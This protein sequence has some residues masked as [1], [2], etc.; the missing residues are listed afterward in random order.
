LAEAGDASAV[1]PVDGGAAPDAGGFGTLLFSS[2]IDLLFDID[3]SA[4][5]GDKQA[6][7]EAA[8]PDLLNRLINP[9]CVDTA[10]PPN[11]VGVSQNGQCPSGAH[12]EFAPVHDL[13]IG[14]VSS[15]LGSR[16][17]DSIC[18][19]N[20]QA[21][22]PFQNVSAH[23]D[24]QAHLLER[25]LV[26]N[27]TTATEGA[28]TDTSSGFL[29]WF[30]TG[31][32]NAGVPP[33]RGTPISNAT[34]LETDFSSLV[35]GVGVF[36]C[37]IESQMESWYR[38]LIQPD[39]YQ[40]LM[41]NGFQAQWS[42]IDTTILQQRHDF[43]R[44]D[45]LVAVIS[46]SDENDSEI[47]VRSLN[48]QGY[49]WMQRGFKPPH[50][51]SA[52]GT[53]PA[54]P[55]CVSCAQVPK[56]GGVSADPN[57]ASAYTLPNDWGWDPNLRHV[58]MKAKY[59]VDPQFPIQRYLNGLTSRTVPDRN[60]EYPSGA[61]AYQGQNDCTNP[62]FAAVLPDGTN[63]DPA[64]LCHLAVSERTPRLVFYA[65]IGGVPHELLHFVANDPQ[66]STL[67]GD[68]WVKILGQGLATFHPGMPIDSSTNN[69]YDTTGIDP[70]M[71]ESYQPRAGL[72]PP[73][74]ANGADPI[75]GREWITDQEQ[76][77]N[78]HV[79]RVDREFACIFPL[80]QPRD[81]SLPQNSDLC[82]CPATAGLT[83][84][85]TPPICD[86]NTQTQQV[87]AKAYPTIR[88]LLL[89]RLMA[90]QG[91]IGSICPQHVTEQSA[92]DPLYGY[93]PAMNMLIS[94]FAPA[95]R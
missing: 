20:A 13:H 51:S 72:Q 66:A 65:H 1:V 47:D 56:D 77:P 19:P 9:N 23:N 88:E 81:C 82:D 58:H 4:S 64:S 21:P 91:V 48:G 95:I 11:I 41:L 70:H 60:G 89:A 92:G 49:L 24:D 57:C 78:V 3:N 71:I 75:S 2:K 25:S 87:G 94:R 84:E 16:L 14:I 37:G 32:A 69:P 40:T 53:D 74:A 67:T 30:P 15:A 52:C 39:P 83:A 8:I 93:R 38:F 54:D 31:G 85:Q 5:M 90:G 26:I 61:S 36:G 18:D 86:P 76:T 12:A 63:T 55:N 46:L 80:A 73:S 43:L 22:A 50:G 62:L 42:G 35:A 68:D 44:P 28:V 79:L 34:R 45:S 33:S 10:T 27:G 29:Y 7:L 17:S 6:Y 59:G